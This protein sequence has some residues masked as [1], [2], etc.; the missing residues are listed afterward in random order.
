MSTTDHFR[1]GRIA[2]A[3]RPNVGKSTLL[4]ALLDYKLAIVAPKAQTTRQCIAGLLNWPD[5]QAMVYDTPG[6]NSRP[7]RLL[8]RQ[9]NQGAEHLL[10]TMDHLYFVIEALKFGTADRYVLDRLRASGRPLSLVVNKIDRAR[11]R[12]RLLPFIASMANEL[13]GSAVF[14]TAASRADGIAALRAAM[15]EVLPAG[16]AQFD[17]DQL[18]DQPVRFLA[19]ELIREQVMIATHQEVP[20][21]T[22]V[23]IERFD[24]S[25]AQVQVAALIQVERESQKGIL[26]GADGA[27]LKVIGSAAREALMDLLGRRVHLELW[28]RVQADWPDQPSAL[29]RFGYM[30]ALD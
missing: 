8:N 3:G 27:R 7:E 17:V 16:E 15:R 11:P 10:A 20:H 18:S 21:S 6:L 2:L 22:A 4:N 28:V 14:L 9:L 26:I 5:A 1:F 19:A 24:E 25:G 23:E 12:E 29:R 13:P 30:T